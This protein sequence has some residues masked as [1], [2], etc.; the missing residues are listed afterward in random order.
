MAEPEPP[1]VAAPASLS[2][3]L[4]RLRRARRRR[5]ISASRA[6]VLAGV[7]AFALA[8]VESLARPWPPAPEIHDEFSYLLASDTFVRGRLANPPHPLWPHFETFHVLQQPTYASKYPPAQSLALAAGQLL[9]GHPIVGVW[10]SFALMAAAITWMLLGWFTPRWSVWGSVFT[11]LVLLGTQAEHAQ[12]ARS[13]WGGAVAA[14]GGALVLGGVRRIMTGTPRSAAWLTGIGLVILANSRPY[15][16][17]L[18]ALPSGLLLAGWLARGRDVAAS[19]TRIRALVPLAA[20]LFAGAAFMGYFNWRVT[21]LATQLP[22]S[23]HQ[24]TYGTT[25]VFLWQA[26]R[27]PDYRN[28]ELRKF[29]MSRQNPPAPGSVLA[30]VRGVMQRV[31]TAA[32]FF[33]PSFAM[34][35]L[36]VAASVESLRRS[37]WFPVACWTVAITVAGS[38]VTSWLQPHYLAPMTGALAL[39]FSGG[40]R[41]LAALRLGRHRT[42]RVVVAATLLLATLGAADNALRSYLE[43]GGTARRWPAQRMAILAR[44]RATAGTH[45]VVI[46]YGPQHSFLAE[47]VHNGADIDGSKV[48]WARSL[49]PISDARVLEYY[50]DRKAWSLFVD[51]DDGPFELKPLEPRS[52]P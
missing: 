42:G 51:R 12:W 45:V 10:M 40:A 21:G 37:S 29:Y 38:F 3:P 34:L 33:A 17:M 18:A 44:L 50:R 26:R 27:G 20:V 8:A 48:V 41:H 13:Y 6:V 49:D 25:P 15:E 28:E 7:V 24:S 22:Y 16:G 31:I 5:R 46:R 30:F 19:A 32:S 14:I 52:L 36:I 9:T 35:L 11:A 1:A 43:R 2:P 47:W 4:A 39:L 23:V